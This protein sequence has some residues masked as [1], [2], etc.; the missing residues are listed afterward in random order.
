MVRKRR[1][2]KNLIGSILVLLILAVYFFANP[3]DT[4]DSGE[5]GDIPT[6]SAESPDEIQGDLLVSFIDVGQADSI[7]VEQ[8]EQTLLIDCGTKDAGEQVLQYLEARSVEALDYLVLTHPH[9]D[10]I[11]GAVAVLDAVPVT[12]AYMPNKPHTTATYGNTLQKLAEKQVAVTA[13]QAGDSFYVGEALVEILGPVTIY[14]DLNDCSVV[15]RLTYG[16]NSFLFTGDAEAAAEED[17]LKKGS[18]LAA[19]LLKVGHHG[20]ETSS[21]QAFLDA[22]SPKIAV[23]SC[24]EDNEYGHPHADTLNRLQALGVTVFRTD[25]KGTIQAVSDG[26]EITMYMGK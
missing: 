10:H 17:I 7:L 9:E 13:A 15:L 25:Q 1:S 11:G 23:I 12:Q 18:K 6:L 8:G 2:P 4:Q 26:K 5:G 21:S 3:A 20:S 14:S 24:G 22:V 19:D 16:E